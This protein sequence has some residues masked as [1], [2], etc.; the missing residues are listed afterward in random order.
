[1]AEGLSS[2][3]A[4][5]APQQHLYPLSQTTAW[6]KVPVSPLLGPESLDSPLMTTE[7]KLPLLTSYRKQ[8]TSAL[9]V[10]GERRRQGVGRRGVGCAGLGGS[11]R[12]VNEAWTQRCDLLCFREGS[13]GHWV[14]ADE[15][16]SDEG[17]V[18]ADKGAA[19]V[20]GAGGEA[21]RMWAVT[22]G[23]GYPKTVQ[24]P[25]GWAGQGQSWGTRGAPRP[26]QGG[27]EHRR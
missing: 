1:M 13:H 25:G 5:L 6:H 8:K 23:R 18:E 9:R 3:W 22:K 17:E 10:P 7:R 16:H 15:S 2:G 19:L 4:V 24:W 20:M 11:D 21:T 14:Q 12:S 26:P 27:C